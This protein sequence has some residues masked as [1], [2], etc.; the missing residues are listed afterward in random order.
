MPSRSNVY[1][2]VAGYVGRP[3]QQGKVGVFR[4][5]AD[6]G[7]WQ[8]V[9]TQHECHAVCV[10]PTERDVVLAGTADGVW[11]SRDRGATFARTRFP[12]AN[13]QIWSILVDAGNPQ[14]V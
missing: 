8:H 2:G 7:D 5:S 3:D 11:R 4:R 1:A 13:T 14:R 12:D 10:H 6:G 9:L